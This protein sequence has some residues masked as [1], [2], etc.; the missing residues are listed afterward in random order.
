M[1]PRVAAPPVIVSNL[2]GPAW[3]GAAGE[4]FARLRDPRVRNLCQSLPTRLAAVFVRRP[5]RGGTPGTELQWAQAALAFRAEEPI[6]RVVVT[7]RTKDCGTLT[8]PSV[9]TSGDRDGESP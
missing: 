2:H 9:S 4:T 5:V 6:D 7:K 3:E 8:S 1:F